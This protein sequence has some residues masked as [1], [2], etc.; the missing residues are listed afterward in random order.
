MNASSSLARN[1]QTWQGL[2]A[3]DALAIDRGLQTAHAIVDH[4]R[5]DCDIEFLRGH[6][7]S[8]N[9]VMEELFAAAGLATGLIPSL[10]VLHDAADSVVLT[11]PNDFIRRRFVEA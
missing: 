2:A 6:C 7:R 4:R 9:D 8:R 5:D 11:M 10:V 1:V 3:L